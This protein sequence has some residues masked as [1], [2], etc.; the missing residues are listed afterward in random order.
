MRRCMSTSTQSA[1]SLLVFAP[2]VDSSTE[3]M[4]SKADTSC[5]TEANLSDLYVVIALQ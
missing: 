1:P 4:S 2:I 5:D 3:H